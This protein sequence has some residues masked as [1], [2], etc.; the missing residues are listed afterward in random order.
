MKNLIL[1]PIDIDILVDRIVSKVTENVINAV[2][3]DK[4]REQQTQPEYLTGKQ[5]NELLS[6]A[7]TTRHKYVREGLLIKHRI[8]GKVLYKRSE[9]LDALRKM[10]QKRKY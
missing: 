8:G 7:N 6:I 2:K 5:V 4:N 1:S 9:V 10:E 3:D